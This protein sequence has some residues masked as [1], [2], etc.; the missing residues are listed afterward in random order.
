MRN[1]S[2]LQNWQRLK[3]K[4]LELAGIWGKMLAGC[5]VGNTD[6]YTDSNGKFGK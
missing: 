1:H 4:Y 6:A 5:A 3:R 2:G